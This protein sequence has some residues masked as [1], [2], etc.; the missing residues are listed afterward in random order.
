MYWCLEVRNWE[1]CVCTYVFG[2]SGAN[3]LS[4]GYV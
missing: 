1:T 3:D 2:D 4:R